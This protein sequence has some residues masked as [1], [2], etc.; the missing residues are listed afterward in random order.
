MNSLDITKDHRSSLLNDSLLLNLHA[1]ME[2]DALC[3]AEEKWI[4]SLVP[5]FGVAVGLTPAS[6][7]P[8]YAY[9]TIY[10]FGNDPNWERRYD[11]TQNP[12][13]GFVRAHPG[14]K[15]VFDADIYENENAMREHP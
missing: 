6:F 15:F 1:T 3:L 11:P 10:G 9:S 8:L 2:P 5:C 12:I 14:R 7:L 4:K 13:L